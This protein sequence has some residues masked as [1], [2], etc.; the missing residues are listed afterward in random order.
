MQIVRL[1]KCQI[2]LA[3]FRRFA[4]HLRF[5]ARRK[6]R[7]KLVRH[8]LRQVGLDREHVGQFTIVILCPEVPIVLRIDKL[9]I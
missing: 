4:R 1:H 2:G 5:L 6:L 9:H 3:T 7:A 8:L